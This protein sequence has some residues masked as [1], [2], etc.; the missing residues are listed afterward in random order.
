MVINDSPNVLFERMNSKPGVPLSSRSSGM[1]MRCSISSAAKPGAWVT[2]CELVS[3][4][5]G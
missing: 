3:A 1:V 4:M 2:T 5:S